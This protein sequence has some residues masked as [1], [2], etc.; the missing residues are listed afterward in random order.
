MSYVIVA[1][2]L[3]LIGINLYY[4]LHVRKNYGAANGNTAVSATEQQCA[5]DWLVTIIDKEI[6]APLSIIAGYLQIAGHEK[7]MPFAVSRNIQMAQET[8]IQIE[9]FIS[10]ITAYRR[11]NSAEFQPHNEPVNLSALIL[12]IAS[13][14]RKRA[15]KRGLQLST[16]ID[17]SMHH[18]FLTDYSLMEQIIT[19]L[20]SNSVNYT[21]R[22]TIAVEAK[23]VDEQ[24]IITVEDSGVGI[25]SD[26]VK[27]FFDSEVVKPHLA[28]GHGGLGILLVRKAVSALHG[29]ISCKSEIN[30]GTTITL[31]FPLDL[32]EKLS[33]D[34]E[35]KLLPRKYAAMKVDDVE[36]LADMVT[37][38]NKYLDDLV[39]KD[40]VATL[41]DN[42]HV[43]ALIGDPQECEEIIARLVPMIHEHDNLKIIHA[44]IHQFD[45]GEARSVVEALAS[46]QGVV[47]LGGRYV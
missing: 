27:R 18:S 3:V 24:V 12:T 8:T 5:G 34:Q 45:F 17:A 35:S 23:R 31:T 41:L 46:K 28:N 44:M 25:S 47:L 21:L 20:I 9:H 19:S 22:G 30:V 39:Q 32:V 16:T 10:E 29:M 42:L 40:D 37:I 11:Y 15:Q 33:V 38:P 26:M 43:A 13:E 36:P 2:L 4:I 7:N 1:L 6:S 14:Q